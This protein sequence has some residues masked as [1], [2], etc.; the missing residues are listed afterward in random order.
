MQ[1]DT[2][3]E[4]KYQQK[5]VEV[6]RLREQLKK[7]E[8]EIAAYRKDNELLKVELETINQGKHQLL[9]KMSEITN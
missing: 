3:M 2:V 8:E 6:A 7:H 4:E 5:E 9:V 1:Q